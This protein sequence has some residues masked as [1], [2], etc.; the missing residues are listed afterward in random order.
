[1]DT[2]PTLKTGLDTVVDELE[3]L[4]P[5]PPPP[6]DVNTTPDVRRHGVQGVR[7]VPELRGGGKP[8]PVGGSPSL[9]MR[10][11]YSTKGVCPTHGQG[12]KKFNGG[13]ELVVTK[14]G[15]TKKKYNR[16]KYFVCDV[17]PVDS[18]KLKQSTLQFP[19]M[20]QDDRRGRGDA[21]DNSRMGEG[22]L[23]YCNLCTSKAGQDMSCEQ[24]TGSE[25]KGRGSVNKTACIKEKVL[26]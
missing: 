7:M 2:K 20:M 12:I 21:D 14:D 26:N 1:M 9:R 22:V 16:K 5:P 23:K 15:K 17:D 18:K 25:E 4:P 6:T 13:H 24:C 3:E 8:V 11:S 19:K 10:C